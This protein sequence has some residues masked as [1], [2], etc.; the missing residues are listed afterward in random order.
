M[1]PEERFWQGLR[2]RVLEHQPRFVAQ[3]WTDRLADA[4]PDV[5]WTWNGRT[6][7]TELKVAPAHVRAPDLFTPAFRRGQP[8]WL[9]RW[10]Q[11][12]ALTSV[13]LHVPPV[14]L[15]V[16]RPYADDLQW[17]RWVQDGALS[18]THPAVQVLRCGNVRRA[19]AET[20]AQWLWTAWTSASP[21]GP[22]G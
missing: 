10:A 1:K 13:T 18:L 2:T 20:I 7:L 8:A 14:G 9:W 6:G 12:G 16:L 3:R 4:V 17:V 22:L 11:A 19:D 21:T 5:L 15:V